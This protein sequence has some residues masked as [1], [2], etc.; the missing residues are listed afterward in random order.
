MKKAIHIFDFDGTLIDSSHRYRLNDSGKIDLKY[1][2]ANEHKADR[3]S[4][5]PLVADFQSLASDPQCYVIIATARVWCPLADT[6]CKRYNIVPHKLVSREGRN[7]SR[8]GAQLKLAAVLPLLNLKQFSNV[9]RVHVWEDNIAY[10]KNMC[11]IL[12]NSIGHYIPSKQ[13]H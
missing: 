3:D 9:E 5:L 4:A 10:L 1:W 11:D 6:V 12:P 13:G 2:M 8:A 7:D